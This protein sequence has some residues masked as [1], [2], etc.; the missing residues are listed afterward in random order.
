M[1]QHT[2]AQN[3]GPEAKIQKV[4][5]TVQN[6]TRKT[7]ETIDSAAQKL[8][9]NLHSEKEAEFNKLHV[10]AAGE[11]TGKF[12]PKA[13]DTNADNNNNEYKGVVEDRISIINMLNRNVDLNG[14][15]KS[16]HSKKSG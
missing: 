4:V 13:D 3:A 5:I 16:P 15:F 9:E 6:C 2:E 1:I 7:L 11:F 12:P 8:S 10:F 14:L